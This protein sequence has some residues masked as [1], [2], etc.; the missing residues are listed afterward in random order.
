MRS[1]YSAFVVGDEAWLRTS[2]HPSTRPRRIHVSEEDRWL[3]LTVV[4]A[5][6]GPLD[7]EG[8][9]HFVAEVERSGAVTRLEERSR[10]VRHGGA[11]VY[12]DGAGT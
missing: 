7:A 5:R 2:W 6:G 8:V 9:V 1:R 12:L 4:S 3:G 11:W 10:F